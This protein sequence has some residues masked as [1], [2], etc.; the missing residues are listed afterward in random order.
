MLTNSSGRARTTT[1][2]LAP[3]LPDVT[4]SVAQQTPPVAFFVFLGFFLG[5]AFFGADFFFAGFFLAMSSLLLLGPAVHGLSTP[6]AH[7]TNPPGRRQ[8]MSTVEI[9]H[10]S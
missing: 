5:A 1:R 3:T 9:D 4:S 6:T 8:G 2:A 10:A 7:P